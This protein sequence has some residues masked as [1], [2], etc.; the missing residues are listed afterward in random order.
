MAPQPLTGRYK[1]YKAGTA[2]LVD[3]LAT[4][5]S[6][7]CDIRIVIKSLAGSGN[8]QSKPIRPPGKS[9]GPE[10][11]ELSTQ[12][13][14][15]LA[16]AIIS[17][18]PPVDI[19][20]HIIEIIR[21]VIGGR[22]EC[23]AWYA[24][25]A[26]EIGSDVQKQNETHRYFIMVLERIL[27]LL[28]DARSRLKVAVPTVTPVTNAKTSAKQ[29]NLTSK[30]EE[31]SNMFACLD[32][33][34][35]SEILL[36]PPASIATPSI[37]LVNF[38]L[39]KKQDDAAFQV[40]C[41]LQDLTDVREYVKNT[42]LEY[43]KGEVSFLVASSV[44][45]TAFG[46]L[47]CA[48]EEFTETSPLQD[49]GWESLLEFF[50]LT[51]FARGNVVWLC[52]EKP[53]D[54]PKEQQ[55][56]I[57]IVEL[58]CPIAHRAIWN[59]ALDM[60]ALCQAEAAR[61]KGEKFE[62]LGLES[63][64]GWHHF[65]E[66][67]LEL[68][69]QL[70]EITH[71]SSCRHVVLDEFVQGLVECHSK[72]RVPM[73]VVHAC[74]IYLDIYDMLGDHVEHGA[75][76]ID[77]AL[78]RYDEIVTNLRRYSI[79]YN[80]KLE[81]VRNGVNRLTAVVKAQ[82]RYEA[83]RFTDERAD[84][85]MDDD[86]IFSHADCKDG[87]C[88]ATCLDENEHATREHPTSLMERLLPAHAGAVLLDWAVSM[89]DAGCMLANH[90]FIVL[91]IAHLYKYM[92]TTGLLKSDWHDMEFVLSSNKQT[93]VTKL[94][95]GV[96]WAAARHYLMA[97]GVPASDFTEYNPI[98]GA[99][100]APFNKPR[101]IEVTS[102]LLKAIGDRES[103]C[104]PRG[105]HHTKSKT[106][107]CVLHALSASSKQSPDGHKQTKKDT[108][109]PLRLL[110]TFKKSLQAVEPQ[111]S[112]DY[113]SFMMSCTDLLD[114][115]SNTTRP[116]F[117]DHK[118]IRGHT[119]LIQRLLYCPASDT[120]LITAAKAIDAH[121]TTT[122]RTFSKQ[123]F[124]QS[125]GRIPKALR[126]KVEKHMAVY[127]PG[128]EMTGLVLASAGTK[129]SFSGSS[130]CAYHPEILSECSDP[131]CPHS[132]LR[133]DEIETNPLN[134][135]HQGKMPVMAF[136]SA[137]P[138]GIVQ[139][140]KRAIEEDPGQWERTVDEVVGRMRAKYEEGELEAGQ[141]LETMG[142]I[143][144]LFGYG[145][146][147]LEEQVLAMG[148]LPAIQEEEEEGGGGGRRRLLEAE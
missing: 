14:I 69:P 142:T 9:K 144:G 92:R 65:C 56:S 136:G 43:V 122:G 79:K 83:M 118:P 20:E 3:W 135:L 46:L 111:L 10:T 123:A 32:L 70:H 37:K 33:E 44:T 97:L 146:R 71:G 29:A 106:V 28:A 42:W 88:K 119:D 80:D 8:V 109:T 52:P 11:V 13:L 128:R 25:Q 35:P 57:N 89:H 87:C 27:D 110:D 132:T 16:E 59:Y 100:R 114:T 31:L 77:A 30:E 21:N 78:G 115:I 5:A 131:K 137:I 48:D 126:P 113:I 134:L 76:A 129:Y 7:C 64:Y 147:V 49:S 36:E 91:S 133:G 99:K 130:L 68:T 23:A 67:L 107:E 96:H 104:K 93:L 82:N 55:S 74:Q 116:Y 84:S 34:E 108:I 51:S 18:R 58:L 47:R 60:A 72:R 40:W 139:G 45:D 98:P 121:I 75:G 120:A 138:P 127:D 39:Q 143:V 1:L 38:R 19:P 90:D 63:W 73:W 112:F 12:E 81:D 105:H 145:D 148:L 17:A 141:V 61:R 15:Q 50:G 95:P 2:K 53:G 85:P 124:D 6:R 4:T 22:R 86:A 101:Q 66:V 117:P 54:H 41:F 62:G 102:D 24:G 94:K 26:L 140:C 103:S 125:S